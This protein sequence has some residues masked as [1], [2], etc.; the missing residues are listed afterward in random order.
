[1]VIYY[2]EKMHNEEEVKLAAH[3]KAFA[4]IYFLKKEVQDYKRRIK[5]DDYEPF[6]TKEQ[7]VSLL[8]STIRQLYMWNYIAK[9]IELDYN[10]IDYLN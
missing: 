6:I 4:K 9:L 3:D 1:M 5:E 10:K 2:L 7:T 8:N